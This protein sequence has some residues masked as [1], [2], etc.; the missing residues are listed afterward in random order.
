MHLCEK[1]SVPSQS[2]T[3]LFFMWYEIP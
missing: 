1:Q 3:W 2:E